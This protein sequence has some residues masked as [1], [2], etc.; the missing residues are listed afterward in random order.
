MDQL[1][2]AAPTIMDGDQVFFENNVEIAP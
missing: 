2:A 1:N